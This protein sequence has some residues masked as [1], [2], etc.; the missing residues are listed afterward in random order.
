[1][2]SPNIKFTQVPEGIRKPGVYFEYN[3]SLA[4]RGLPT[5]ENSVLLM[6]LRTDS[7]SVAENVPT[8]IFGSE[9]AKL[10][11]GA[12]SNLHVMAISLY[13]ANPYLTDVTC[14]ALD[15]E[16]G[17]A[18]EGQWGFTGTATSSGTITSWIQDQRIDMSVANEDTADEIATALEAKIAEYEDTLPITAGVSSNVV[19]L[20]ARSHGTDGDYVPMAQEIDV[21]GI[22]TT[23]ETGFIGGATDP[24][25]ADAL[26][27]VFPGE[28]DI[29]ISEFLDDTALGLISTHIDTKSNAIEMRP[30][31]VTFGYTELAGNAATL[32]TLTGTTLN[33]GR[34][35]AATL[36]YTTT[37]GPQASP[38]QIAAAYGGVLG[39]ATDPAVPYNN[40]AL[41][42]IPVPAVADRFARSV[43]EDYLDNGV[44]PL[45]VIP[46]NK[47]AIVRAIST[48]TTNAAGTAD[49]SLLDITTMRTLDYTR[50]SVVTRLEN[51]FPRAKLSS[52]TPSKVRT[53]V[54]DVLR[55]LED[56]EILEEVEANKAGVLVERDSSDANRLNVRIPADVVNGLHVIAGKF[57]LLL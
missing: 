44:T 54:L 7:G 43:Q 51:R 6:G 10:Y 48:Y 34:I 33:D 12:G 25:V 56:L 46:G 55:I 36:E 18:A 27:A 5:I 26:T 3:T 17:T 37:V 20:T 22:M 15:A 49:P 45:H 40:L 31:V 50:D 35:S 38:M 11:F 30:A 23:G 47:T 14:V 8:K 21:A 53:Q 2:G 42:G 57:D 29:Y 52:K 28:Y 4:V 9:D 32:K 16:S 13:K 1:M 24:S 19:T 41:T 39:S